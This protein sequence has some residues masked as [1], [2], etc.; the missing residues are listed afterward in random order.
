MPAMKDTVFI[1][2]LKKIELLAQEGKLKIKHWYLQT[3]LVSLLVKFE[4]LTAWEASVGVSGKVR[5]ARRMIRYGCKLGF[6]EQNI[7]SIRRGACYIKIRSSE[8]PGANRFTDTNF[9]QLDS[10]MRSIVFNQPTDIY[11]A[12]VGSLVEESKLLEQASR[13]R[14][15]EE[16]KLKEAY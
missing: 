3:D 11:E 16:L 9:Q 14:F 13:N 7:S 2:H 10:S 15:L 6:F 4:V 1:E 5:P 12:L 8:I